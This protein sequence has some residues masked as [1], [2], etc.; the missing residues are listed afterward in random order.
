ML[1]DQLGSLDDIYDRV[2]IV[3]KGNPLPSIVNLVW[4]S[5]EKGAEESNRKVLVFVPARALCDKLSLVLADT[6]KKRRDVY[7]GA[8][9]GSLHRDLR[10]QAEKKFMA[11]RDA[12]LVAT[13][14]LE[15][16]IDIGDVDMVALVGA[17]HNTSSLLQRIGRSG[18]RNGCVRV[19]PIAQNRIEAR[20]FSSMLDYAFRGVLDP[21]PN[22]RLW[23]V[24]VQQATSHTAQADKS[25]RLRRDLLNLAQEV[26]PET[27]APATAVQILDFLVEQGLLEEKQERFFPGPILSDRLDRPGGNALIRRQRPG[28]RTGSN[29]RIELLKH[30]P[31]S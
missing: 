15:V 28:Q 10:E 21:T 24:F 3:P 29:V 26:W 1:F 2:S 19:L 14:T 17:P 6:V 30:G 13:T 16:G 7:V 31:V 12:I 9:H 20:A 4:S 25:G 23:S 8:H 18:R 11:C 5:I 22:A 27:P